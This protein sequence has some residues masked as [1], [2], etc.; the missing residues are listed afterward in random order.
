M[1]F[2]NLRIFYLRVDFFYFSSF[3]S[4]ENHET[5]IIDNVHYV[6]Q[7]KPKVGCSALIFRSLVD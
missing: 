3:N 5:V 7:D 6:E 4:F 2:Y 1:Q